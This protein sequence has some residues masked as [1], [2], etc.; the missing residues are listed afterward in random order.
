MAMRMNPQAAQVSALPSVN[1]TSL[2]LFAGLALILVNFWL[3]N[4]SNF[5]NLF[6]KPG[7]QAQPSYG[8]IDL[9]VQALGLFLLVLL[10]EYGGD[11]AGAFA[12]VFLAALW[13]LWLLGHVGG[14]GAKP[15]NK[16][17]PGGSGR[18][19]K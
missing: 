13:L 3:V 4:G 6:F 8:Y 12:L 10:S 16:P 5:L 11:G 18:T 17:T 2:I 7:T 19:V 15:S 9:G 14:L 1:R